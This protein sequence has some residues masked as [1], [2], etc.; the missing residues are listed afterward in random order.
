MRFVVIRRL[1][2]IAAGVTVLVGSVP[3]AQAAP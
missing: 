3:S 1:A 2:L